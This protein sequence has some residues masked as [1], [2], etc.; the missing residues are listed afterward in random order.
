MS[1]P[2]VHFEI[3]CQDS[4]RTQEF[5]SNLFGWKI[6]VQGPAAMINTGSET[7]I[8]GHISSLGHEPHQYVTVYVEVDDLQ[9][10]LNKAEELGGKT[11]IPPT[12][13]PQAGAFAWF[14]DIG[15]NC[16]GLWKPMG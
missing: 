6:D 16:I 15:G 5:Y 2:V 9:A 8:H 13:I 12:E 7:G 1:N 14:T 4:P 11:V 10:Y 3:G